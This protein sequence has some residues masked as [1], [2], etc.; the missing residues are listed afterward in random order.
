M[1]VWPSYHTAEEYYRPYFNDDDP[2]FSTA[3][4]WKPNIP[5][6]NSSER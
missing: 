1:I 2:K 4:F 5:N 3:M 6:C